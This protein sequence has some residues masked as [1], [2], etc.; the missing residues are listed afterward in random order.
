M[1][2]SYAGFP[3]LTLPAAF[4]CIAAYSLVSCQRDRLPIP[5]H[6]LCPR[7]FR[8]FAARERLTLFAAFCL[9]FAGL[10]NVY[11]LPPDR[12]CARTPVSCRAVLAPYLPLPVRACY[13][14]LRLP[15]LPRFRHPRA[16]AARSYRRCAACRTNTCV[17]SLP[18]LYR[19]DTAAV[20]AF[21]RITSVTM[22][23]PCH[24]AP[25]RMILLV[26]ITLRR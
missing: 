26:L 23:L 19:R 1:P 20:S 25:A 11:T 7:R 10:H 15:F 4:F 18:A 5:P 24:C 12:P 6:A 8:Q 17:R 3:D 21:H 16:D 14:L 22:V 2:F 9:W 13:H